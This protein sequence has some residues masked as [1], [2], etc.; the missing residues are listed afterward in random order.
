VWTLLCVMWSFY[1]LDTVTDGVPRASEGVATR[2]RS[3][4]SSVWISRRTREIRGS[5]QVASPHSSKFP[6]RLHAAER[7]TGSPGRLRSR[8]AP[9]PPSAFGIA[10][11]YDHDA[12]HAW[13]LPSPQQQPGLR[14]AAIASINGSMHAANTLCDRAARPAHSAAWPGIPCKSARRAIHGSTQD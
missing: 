9:L 1:G 14:L 4:S 3:V 11:P 8:H 2:G 6:P 5:K 12:G 13:C 10:R 7:A